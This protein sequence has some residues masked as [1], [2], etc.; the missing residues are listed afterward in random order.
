MYEGRHVRM[1]VGGYVCL[2]VGMYVCIP[3]PL[4]GGMWVYVGVCGIYICM[5]AYMHVCIKVGK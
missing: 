3:P 2:Y 1:N 5:N 4:W